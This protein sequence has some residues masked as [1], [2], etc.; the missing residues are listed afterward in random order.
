M[1][2]DKEK[3]AKHIVSWI[4]EYAKGANRQTLIVG[5]SGGI[6]SALVALLCQA[7]KIDTKCLC[8][9][10]YSSD[11]S[12]KH[13]K[14]F[15][16]DY[17]LKL[18]TIDLSGVFSDIFLKCVTPDKDEYHL[19][20]LNDI[21]V[22]GTLKSCLRAPVLS[23]MSNA[24]QG[25]VVGTGNRSE[26]NLIRY[27]NKF[28]DGCVDLSPIGDLFKSEVYYLF[29]FL[30]E[31]K[32][33]GSMS[34]SAKDIYDKAPS[35]DLWENIEQTD[36][37]ELGLT[38]DEIE[39]ADKQNQ[40]TN[41]IVNETDPVKNKAWM[42]YTGRQRVVIAKIHAMEKISRHKY[43]PNIPICKLRDKKWLIK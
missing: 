2:V 18:D 27:Y 19:K 39:W 9:P 6:D 5:L 11:L 30:A 26:D 38:Y 17:K 13:A 24:Y 35:A 41:I 22:Q 12:Y 32:N 21:T 31:K 43:N 36:E 16:R 33:K 3:L 14:E 23:Y 40:K 29:K 34:N 15:A 8:L 25:L 20:R 10:C 4:K 42:G 7:T 1:I 28:G 37:E